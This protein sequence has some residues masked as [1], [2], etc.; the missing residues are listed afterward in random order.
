[1]SFENN[2]LTFILFFTSTKKNNA[3]VYLNMIKS[4]TNTRTTDDIGI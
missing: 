4:I 1:M 2:I 3:C